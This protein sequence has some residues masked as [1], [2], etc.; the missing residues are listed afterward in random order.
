M[1]FNLLL[2][3]I[4]NSKSI[5]FGTV[6]GKAIEL[7]KKTWGHGVLLVIV[8]FLLALPALMILYVPIIGAAI[9]QSNN[10][11]MGSEMSPV[12]M[13]PFF[14]LLLPVLLIIQT[15]SLGL[16]AG[17]YK[18]VRS[19]DLNREVE[20]NSLFMFLKKPYLGKLFKLSFFSLVIALLAT[21][22]CVFPVI[23]VSVPL[24]FISIIFAFNPELSAKETLKASFKLGNKKWL[25]TF[26]LIVVSS[27]LAQMVGM[28][29]CGIGLLF[30]ASFTYLPTYLVYKEAVGFD[31]DNEISQIGTSEV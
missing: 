2:E 29:L 26:G 23:Y 5:D 21:L 13:I 6:F 24:I 18:I 27:F 20:N 4:E 11:E 7:F 14:L 31:D 12:A 25:I 19:K 9:A 1:N 22:L 17:F 30:T 10:P 28:I 8:T 16:M 3:K 15:I